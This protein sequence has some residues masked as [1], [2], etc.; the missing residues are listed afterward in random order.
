MT[1]RGDTKRIDELIKRC[2]DSSR[3][4]PD[5]LFQCVRGRLLYARGR[6]D[7][8][9]AAYALATESH[10]SMPVLRKDA[11]AHAARCYFELYQKGREDALPAAAKFV[12]QR[13][14]IGPVGSGQA[15]LL[16]KI[17]LAAGD[18]D[19]AR[20]L[21]N[22]LQL[23]KSDPWLAVRQA[24]I[25]LADGNYL[26]AVTLVR[27]VPAGSDLVKEANRINEESLKRSSERANEVA[28]AL[29]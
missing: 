4:H 11:F 18:F 17:A 19:S 20:S 5:G 8:A 16:S 6:L 1:G 14:E 13:L 21:L 29:K 27:R 3:I 28:E 9:A 26:E 25:E 23:L 24:E 7:E 22:Q 12:K 15:E 2:E 10:F